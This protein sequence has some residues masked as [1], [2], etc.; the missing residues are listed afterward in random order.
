MCLGCGGAQICAELSP[1][2]LI[3]FSRLYARTHNNCKCGSR[4]IST[5]LSSLTAENGD[6]LFF[7]ALN[8]LS[9]FLPLTR[10]PFSKASFSG[11]QGVPR[12][13]ELGGP[14]LMPEDISTALPHS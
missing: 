14:Q 3:Q 8:K 6:A 5:E 10:G 11:L 12:N 9:I 2:V 7:L 4:S 1:S 13:P